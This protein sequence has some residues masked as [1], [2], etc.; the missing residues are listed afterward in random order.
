[1]DKIWNCLFL[2]AVVSC[3]PLSA[4]SQISYDGTECV[5][6]R[7]QV[8][9]HVAVDSAMRQP[10]FTQ[11]EIDQAL[12][13]TSVFFDDICMSFIQCEYNVMQ[14]DYTLGIVRSSPISVDVRLSELRNRF[15]KRRRI[16]MFFLES[17]E[18]ADCGIGTFRGINTLNDAN[19]FIER[20][21]NEGLATQIAHQLGHVFGL[22]DTHH[23]EGM[24]LVDGS[25]CT[26][27]GDMLCSTPADPF[28]QS[29]ISSADSIRLLTMDLITDFSIECEFV[30]E[31]RDPNDDFYNPLISN[32]MSAYPCKCSFTQE[33]LSVMAS[34]YKSS[35]IKHF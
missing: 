1:M 14:N 29:F 9:T 34:N 24:E 3:W 18:D 15:S 17:I 25:N 23:P 21:C 31:L 5:N 12:E 26:I 35:P 27:A 10:L 7:F 6:K 30:Y 4:D 13:A 11:E 2:F 16:N 8:A 28:E 22:L 32:I 33:Q 19:I 20:D